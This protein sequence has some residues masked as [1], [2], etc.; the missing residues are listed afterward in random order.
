MPIRINLLVETQLAE[1][2]RRRDPVKRIIMGG[3]V[4]VALMLLWWSGVQLRVIVA[5][6]DLSQ[7]EAG[8]Q[9]HTNAFQL[10][11]VSQKKINGANEKLAALQKLNRSR[12]LQGNLLNALQQAT[13]DGVQLIRLRVDQTYS[14]TEATEPQTNGTHITAGLSG[15]ITEKIVV[16]LDA[17]DFSSNP[18]DQVNKFKDAISRQPYF[19]T[20][21]SKTNSVRLASLSPPQIGP[22]GRPAVLFTLQCVYPDQTR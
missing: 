19:Q 1:D 10:V 5:E 15:T 21:L 13:V 20:E 9:S 18:G 11:Q 6:K 22:N 8:I 17:R 4:A 2:L 16:S 12:F 14:V 3:A 7:V